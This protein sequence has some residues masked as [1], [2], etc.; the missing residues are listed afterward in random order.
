MT[1]SSVSSDEASSRT[2]RRRS[3]ELE[4]HRLTVS[5]GATLAQHQ[6][7]IKAMSSDERRALLADTEFK[8]ELPPLTGLAMK[9][10]LSLPW[11]K[12][13]SMK[14]YIPLL[15]FL[16]LLLYGSHYRWLARE[17][18]KIASEKKQRLLSQQL[19]TTEIVAE[20]APF[21]RSL[22]DG[23]EE[24]KNDAMAYTPSLPDKIFELLEQHDRY[25]QCIIVV[26]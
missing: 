7:E 23:G 16:L 9:S 3:G 18:V 26:V 6:A 25:G 14:R 21:T 11:S 19:I 24:V 10:D 2:L 20:I 17:G 12:M 13:R 4:Q 1:Q 5:K 15:G 22:K 8:I